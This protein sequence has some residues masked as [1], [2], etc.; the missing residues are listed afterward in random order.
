MVI[1]IGNSRI[2]ASVFE[3]NFPVI[4]LSFDNLKKLAEFTNLERIDYCLISSVTLSDSEL[5]AKFPFSYL[6]LDKNTPLPLYNEYS[7][8]E[9][10]GVDRI[11]AVIGARIHVPTG[12][13]LTIDVGSCI[14]YDFMTAQNHY[15]GGAISPGM[16]MRFKSMNEHTSGLPLVQLDDDQV[17]GIVGNSTVSCLKSGVYNGMVFELKGFIENFQKQ[18]FDLKVIICGGDSKFFESLV[19]DHIFVIPNLVLQGL[20]RILIYNVSKK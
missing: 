16:K 4:E 6:F 10:L 19:K 3:D 1:D 14:T 17:P 8:P 11:A 2:K 5:R 12:P 7:T 18:Y 20:N 15:L 13:V 9:T